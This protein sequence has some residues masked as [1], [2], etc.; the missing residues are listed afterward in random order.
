ML[1]LSEF[2]HPRLN[3]WEAKAYAILHCPFEEV[4]L[5]DADIVPVRDPSF[6]FD[7]DEYQRSGSVLWPDLNRCFFRRSV[8]GYLEASPRPASPTSRVGPAAVS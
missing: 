1:E 8:S 3:G 6:L 5:L 4:L 7:S 2:P